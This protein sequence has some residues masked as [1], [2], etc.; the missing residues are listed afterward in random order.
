M[1]TPQR[2]TPSQPDSAFPTG[3]FRFLALDVET[4]N[5]D[6]GSICQIGVACVR[7]DNSIETWVT[8]VDPQTATWAFTGLHGISQKTVRGAPFFAD[9]L[10]MIEAPL[11]G[12]TIYQ[13]S[14]FDRSAFRAA[15]A[16][17]QR[18]E[19]DWTWQN[20]VTVARRAWPELKGNGGHGLASLK[21]H[22][23]LSFDHHDAGEDARAAAEVVLLA[24]QAHG[25]SV[26]FHDT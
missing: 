16:G 24:E 25:R 19:P 7:P 1:P 9:A 2:H 14:G 21:R 3:P 22:L 18:S 12:V 10:A 4:A 17:L 13:H 5:H 6:R 23:R 11:Q 26:C 15:C 20:S 8:F